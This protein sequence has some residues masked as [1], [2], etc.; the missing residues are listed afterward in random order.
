MKK[1]F[2]Y[3][4]S[5]LIILFISLSVFASSTRE[6]Q[7]NIDFLNSFGW[8]VGNSPIE[9]SEITIPMDFDDVYDEYN[10]I[11]NEAGFDLEE[12]KGKKGTR[13]TYKVLNYPKKE[14]E[15]IRANI[16]IAEKKVIGGDI[17]SVKLD[18]FMHSLIFPEKS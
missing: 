15:D 10:I 5:I 1:M 8:K 17:M 16:L 14:N 9:I 12:F 13:Y 2:L 3:L 4:L 7:K 18:G 11:Q 6:N